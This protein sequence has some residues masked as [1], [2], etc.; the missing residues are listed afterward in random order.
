MEQLK[1]RFL[2]KTKKTLVQYYLKWNLLRCVITAR[3]KNM[4]GA[5]IGLVGQTYEA[6]ENAVF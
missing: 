4:C 6:C 2:S 3:S 5:R 1:A